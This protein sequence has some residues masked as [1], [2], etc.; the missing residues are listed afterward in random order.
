MNSLNLKKLTIMLATKCGFYAMYKT[1]GYLKC[2]KQY[3]GDITKLGIILSKY[4]WFFF[5][6]IKHK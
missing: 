5:M 1:V 4:I 6:G 3:K 2:W